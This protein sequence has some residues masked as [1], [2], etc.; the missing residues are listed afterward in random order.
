[1]RILQL[2]LLTLCATASLAGERGDIDAVTR[3]RSLAIM[4]CA[5]CHMVAPDQPQQP[6]LRPPAPSFASIARRPTLDADWL[7]SFLTTTHRGADKPDGMPNPKLLDS[8]V[9]QVSAY[10]LSLRGR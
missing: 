6:I 1:M 4:I 9:R 8:H 3:G 10:L 7:R 2:L 5:S